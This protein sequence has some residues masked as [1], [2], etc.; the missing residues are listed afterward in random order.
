MT[1]EQA[2]LNLQLG[3]SFAELLESVATVATARIATVADLV[4]ALRHPGVVA[5]QAA[6]VLYRMTGTPL[7]ADRTKLV[8][9]IAEVVGAAYRSESVS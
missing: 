2:K 5:E 3:A 4:P 6:F 8:E 7:P 1:F 9:T